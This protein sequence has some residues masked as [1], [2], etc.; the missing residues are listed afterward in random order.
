MRQ[1]R[2]LALISTLAL[3]VAACVENGPEP[4]STTPDTVE[5]S[6]DVAPL[7]T[8]ATSTTAIDDEP[9]VDKDARDYPDEARDYDNGRG[10]DPELCNPI[11]W[12]VSEL[13]GEPEVDGEA[14]DD[15]MTVWRAT[16]QNS[17]GQAFLVSSASSDA[18]YALEI[19]GS[20]MCI[21]LVP[22]GGDSNITSE[23]ASREDVV[24]EI[25][26]ELNRALT[27][28][29]EARV[30]DGGAELIAESMAQ[31]EPA[32]A[33][34]DQ[35][36]EPLIPRLITFDPLD[37]GS[38]DLDEPT[39]GHF[40]VDPSVGS[41]RYDVYQVRNS[42]YVSALVKSIR[43]TLYAAIRHYP[44]WSKKSTGAATAGKYTRYMKVWQS[45]ADRHFLTV[46][47]YKSSVVYQVWGTWQ[48]ESYSQ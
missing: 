33:E 37:G 8:A 28:A 35:P 39:T 38:V 25:I 48:S 36:E 34:A 1:L 42:K 41:G 14:S 4:T 29:G 20:P 24:A 12:E 15:T 46:Y 40:I 21:E 43:G 47:A 44:D 17:K 3:V 9:P 23:E 27:E 10:S 22:S 11:S 2:I 13:I 5:A 6:G 19:Y 31:L 32:D 30:D 45:P 7:T 16:Y 18:E 26:E